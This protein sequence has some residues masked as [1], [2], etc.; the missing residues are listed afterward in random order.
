MNAMETYFTMFRETLERV[1]GTQMPVMEEAAIRIAR[2]TLEGRRI[3]AFGCNHAGLI[4]L[5]MYYRTGGMVNINPIIAP[6]MHLDVQ[7]PTLTSQMERLA[8]YGRMILDA[9]PIRA[10]DLLIIHS[11]SGRNSVTIDMALRAKELGVFIIALTSL[12]TTNTVTSRH[13]S[14]MKL[15]QIA[16]LVI[17]NCGEL[18]DAMVKIEGL[19][20]KTGPSSTA[21]GAAIFNAIVSRAVEIIMQEGGAPPIF[22]SAN[23]DDGEEK[24][25]TAMNAYQDS[26]MYMR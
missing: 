26:I 22:A 9:C 12:M 23:I 10:N 14:K 20:D 25:L 4:A 1:T 11:V 8:G 17:D 5:E 3:F 7:P 24:N 6:G 21:I 18:G 2:S 19:E 13:N 15:Y 16:D